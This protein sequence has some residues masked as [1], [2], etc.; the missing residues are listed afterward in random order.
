MKTI[1]FFITLHLFYSSDSWSQSHSVET[2]T[3]ST[4]EY[5]F[6]LLER[7]SESG[8]IETLLQKQI[9][10]QIQ[11][12]LRLKKNLLGSKEAKNLK[13]NDLWSLQPI[14]KPQFP[15]IE[16]TEWIQ[17][18]IDYFILNQLEKHSLSP[19][20]EASKE[21]LIRR[22][23]FNLIGLP[24]SPQDVDD[25]LSNNRPDAY[26]KIT[27]KLLG[28]RYYGERWGRHWLD[29]VRYSESQ[30]FEYDNLRENAWH[31]RDYVI[32]SFNQDKPY[33]Q[34]VMEQIAG[35]VID[36]S[37]Y[38][39]IIAT[40]MLVCGAWDQ[41]GSNQ[42]N[43][44]QRTITR[45]E[46]LE[47]LVSVV[48]QSFLGMTINCARCH[49]HK[50]DPIPQK[51]YFRIKSVFEGVRHGERLLAL[52]N[53]LRDVN[54]RIQRQNNRLKT[55]S[56][57]EMALNE[58]IESGGNK[59]SVEELRKNIQE[60][61]TQ[62][63]PINT[64][65]TT[66]AGERVQPSP[67]YRLIR[68]NVKTPAEMVTP[69]A[70]SAISSIDAD[71]G[72]P[73]NAPEG[74]RRLKLAEW[75]VDKNNPLTARVIVNRIWYYHFGQGIV[76]TPNDFGNSGERPSHPQLLDWL[77]SE[78]IEN[79]WSIKHIHRLIVNSATYKQSFQINEKAIQLDTENKWLWRYSPRRLE[80]EIVRD[81]MLAVSGEINL[82]HGGPSFKPFAFSEIENIGH[83]NIMHAD[84]I[85]EEY[86]RRSVYRMNVQSCKDPLLDVFDCPDPTVKAPKR[87]VTT[88]PLQA[89]S[90]MNNS[91]VLRQ[92]MYFAKRIRKHSSL[93]LTS[94]IQQAYQIAYSRTPF[95]KEIDVAHT[96]IE[97]YGLENYC[98]VILNSSEFLYVD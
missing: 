42:A 70:L 50:F 95:K 73:A 47:D 67:T 63:Y 57:L 44:T 62:I 38:Q 6:Q 76:A 48:S 2:K 92:A 52:P 10:N 18:E 39:G 66:Y 93:D 71:F 1:Y 17:N 75:I 54:Q 5:I 69:G 86:N 33:D 49:S 25:F 8:D 46:E 43:E 97:N 19:T 98:W 68:G 53:E 77:A 88:T 61:K 94:Q 81:A 78:L 56:S 35:D 31:Y 89:L 59:E 60:E 15:K 36:S 27:E 20:I 51:D 55:I 90:L 7:I 14:E 32:N 23:Y 37:S 82:K 83:K 4:G 13:Q 3:Q 9:D 29:V 12:S 72:L 87:S 64:F 96:Y 41:A 58:L 30:G 26:E 85:G 80:A 84:K 79:N 65:P 28:S 11:K 24:P 45:E 74:I 34:F 16:N 91:F 22:I 40:S 21:T